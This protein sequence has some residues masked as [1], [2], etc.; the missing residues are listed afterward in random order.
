MVTGKSILALQTLREIL[1]LL[2]QNNKEIKLQTQYV[3]ALGIRGI[4]FS[5]ELFAAVP[6]R[7]IYFSCFYG[8]E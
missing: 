6:K 2:D 1:L 3:S 5:P 4:H 7:K 8:L